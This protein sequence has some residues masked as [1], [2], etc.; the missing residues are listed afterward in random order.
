MQTPEPTAAPAA[1]AGAR[2]RAQRAWALTAWANHGF[3]TTVLVGFFPIFLGKYWAADLAPTRS[4]LLLGLANSAASLVVMLIAPWLGAYADRK[5]QKK[6]WLG[7]FTAIGVIATALL[8]LVGRGEWHWALPVFVVASV[9]FFAGS[10]FQ[11]ALMVQVAT[12]AESNRVSAYGFAAG[13]L[14]GGL[15]FLLNVLLVLHP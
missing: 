12:P 14:G 10:S 11:D 9:G 3:S 1:D 4:T 2:R 7:I 15:L 8:A 5:G 13:Y 6:L